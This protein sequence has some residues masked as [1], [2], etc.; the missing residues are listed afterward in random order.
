MRHDSPTSA[1]SRLDALATTRTAVSTSEEDVPSESE[2]TIRPSSE[3]AHRHL[4][5]LQPILTALKRRGM[6]HGSSIVWAAGMDRR[7]IA[8]LPL[9][10]RTRNCLNQSR[11][12]EGSGP[13]AVSDF[14]LMENFGRKSLHD[15]LGELERFLKA[16]V[17]DAAAAPR[18]NGPADQNTAIIDPSRHDLTEVA[19]D[20]A[21]DWERTAAV[22]RPLLAA[23]AELKGLEVAR[24]RLAWRTY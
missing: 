3:E 20:V 12:L 21:G 11:F 15:F 6:P 5:D 4:H 8:E 10:I 19:A 9:K 14:L 17:H 13:L 22:L 23:A 7:T 1:P 16:C 24:R 2:F 18:R